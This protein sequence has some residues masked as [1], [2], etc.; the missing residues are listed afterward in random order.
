MKQFMAY[1][2]SKADFYRQESRR[3]AEDDR[4]DEG[5][6]A[7]IRANVYGI[8]KSVFQ[9]LDAPKAVCKL[10]GLRNEWEASRRAAQVHGD[11][12]KAAIEEIKLETLAEIQAELQKER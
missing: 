10:D 3:L 5:D 6:L 1:L 12:K 4:R 9:V 8:C 11:G 7:E 2:D